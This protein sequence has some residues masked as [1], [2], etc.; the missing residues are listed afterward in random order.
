MIEAFERD[1]YKSW[2]VQFRAN[3]DAIP[4][5][6][7]HSYAGESQASVYDRKGFPPI[8]LQGHAHAPLLTAIPAVKDDRIEQLERGMDALQDRL[9]TANKARADANFRANENQFKLAEAMEALR[10]IAAYTHI[11]THEQGIVQN[12]EARIAC[13]A[14]AKLEGGE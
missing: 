11:G 4:A 14:L 8:G 2:R 6:P 10:K 1:F 13:T 12:A 5:V 9:D 7:T 3:I